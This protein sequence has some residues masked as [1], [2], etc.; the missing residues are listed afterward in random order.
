MYLSEPFTGTWAAKIAIGCV[1]KEILATMVAC[2]GRIPEDGEGWTSDIEKDQYEAVLRYGEPKPGSKADVTP[3][4]VLSPGGTMYRVVQLQNCSVLCVSPELLEAIDPASIDRE[5]E[6]GMIEGP[7]YTEEDEIY[8]KTN[9][10]TWVI[11]GVDPPRT[12][13]IRA[14]LEKTALVFD[15]EE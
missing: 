12:Q 3:V 9:H 14:A 5:N 15:A 11:R 13:A 2:A 7:Y 10:A 8:A 1:P 6:E 4:C